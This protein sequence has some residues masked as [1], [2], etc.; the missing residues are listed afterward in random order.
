MDESLLNQ[1]FFQNLERINK[2]VLDIEKV[3][4]HSGIKKILQ[5]Q[6]EPSQIY[7][8]LLT[9]VIEQQKRISEL[10]SILPNVNSPMF[11]I[12]NDL[13]PLFDNLV[14]ISKKIELESID[15]DNIS[16]NI[17]YNEIELIT[18]KVNRGIALSKSDIL[19]LIG[20][21]LSLYTLLLP[22]NSDHMKTH[23]MLN[24]LE[25]QVMEIDI[26][27]AIYYEVLQQVHVR[28]EPSS[29]KNSKKID[30]VFP[31]EQVQFIQSKPYWIQVEYFDEN[32]NE[33]IIGWI[34]KKYMRRVENR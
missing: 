5:R 7:Y 30:I 16:S 32:R 9:P 15:K 17:D 22:D 23:E 6:K 20:I 1:E 18:D 29:S 33:T 28:T 8:E 27:Q 34:S 4:E 12:M 14:E 25:K 24:N 31:K 21:L 19:S 2:Q 3:F 11:Q 13:K 10:L 26:N